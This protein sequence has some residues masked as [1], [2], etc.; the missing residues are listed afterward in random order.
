[1]TIQITG[2]DAQFNKD[3]TILGDL[4]IYGS[5]KSK[6]NDT[7]FD[8]SDNFVVKTNETEVFRYPG[9]V[10]ATHILQT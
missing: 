6:T 5:I 2:N 10:E 3:I 9:G 8:F 7:L 4:E 1:M